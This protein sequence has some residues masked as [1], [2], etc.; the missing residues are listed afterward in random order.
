MIAFLA[1]ALSTPLIALIKSGIEFWDAKD[2]RV[3]IILRGIAILGIW[4]GVSG[5]FMFML[6]A[7]V[8][9]AAHSGYRR[10]HGGAPDPSGSD[11]PTGVMTIL[12]VIYSVA[13]GGLSYWMLHRTRE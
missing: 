8:Y 12:S 7:K 5:I 4:A 3:S 10:S 2:D 1:V 9:R 11:D 13:C 6:F